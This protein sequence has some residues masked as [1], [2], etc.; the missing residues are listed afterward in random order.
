ML[1][2]TLALPFH[3]KQLSVTELIDNFKKLLSTHPLQDGSTVS[4]PHLDLV[5]KRIR[6]KCVDEDGKEEWYC[7]CILSL[8]P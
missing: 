8:V 6:H 1:F 2:T 4:S 3:V 5:G 7:G